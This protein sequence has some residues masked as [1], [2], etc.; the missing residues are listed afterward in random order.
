MNVNNSLKIYNNLTQSDAKI[1]TSMERL[2]SGLKVNRAADDAAGKA[3]SEAMKA[4]IRG[5]ETSNRNI[6]DGLSLLDTAESGMGLIIDPN[7]ARMRELTL[8]AAN[9]T[10]TADDRKMIQTE[11]DA[12]KSSI[13]DIANNTEFNTKKV[14]S[15]PTQ[16][17]P[18]ESQ[19]TAIDIVFFID[20]SGTMAEEISLVNAGINSFAEN[21]SQYGNVNIGTVS[22]NTS[23]PGTLSA[24]NNDPKQVSDYISTHHQSEGGLINVYDQLV[25]FAPTGEKASDLGYRSNSKKIFVILT[26]T[27]D[28]ASNHA[29]RETVAQT[30]TSNNIQSYLFGINFYGGDASAQNQFQSDD[31]YTFVNQIYKPQTAA[32]VADNISPGL[33]DAIIRDAELIEE[34]IE[35]IDLQIGPNS[36]HLLRIDLYDCRSEAI[37]LTDIRVEDYSSAMK[38]LDQIDQARELMSHRRTIYGAYT[39]RLEHALRFSENYQL[40]LTTS[41]SRIGDADIPKEAQSLAQNQVLLQSAQAMLSQSMKQSEAVLMLLK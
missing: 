3:I 7:L 12:I 16:F 22:V 8:Q 30:L 38:T 34:A 36:G 26:D 25:D 21:L 11:L 32:D 37:G 40:N 23:K 9:G 27:Y 19:S 31:A 33:T 28:E 20:D 35:P 13:D 14:L 2:S 1:R 41:E 29:T 24:L 5:L 10:L 39:N 6:R 4:Q 18:G 17:T 15:P